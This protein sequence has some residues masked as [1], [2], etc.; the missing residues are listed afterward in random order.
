MQKSRGLINLSKKG[1]LRL[2]GWELKEYLRFPLLEILIIIAIYSILTMPSLEFSFSKS[3]GNL[4]WGIQN[5]FL[6]LTFMVGAL[7][8]RSFAGSYAKGETKL[9]LSYPIKRWQLFFSKFT[10]LFL[11]IFLVY[12]AVFSA[13][14]Y[15]LS[16]SPF[17]P[18]F[19]VSLVGIA[20][21]LLLFCT[22]TTVISLLVKNEIV[23]ILAS[24]LL[25][26]GL[27][28]IASATSYWSS[29]GRFKILFG[30]F[31]TL[32]HGELPPGFMFNPTIS[33]VALAIALPLLISIF[34]LI[35]CAGYYTQKMEID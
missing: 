24:I 7:F 6:F 9:L 19:Y 3:Y 14:V 32:T 22:V 25:L 1:F 21:Q 30:Y 31:G 28:S 15:L 34:L 17:E 20:L 26:Y 11:V 5:V 23:S 10:A 16:L 35:L 18:T 12:G 33:S 4:H 27:E 2:M 8:S 29:A 13:Q